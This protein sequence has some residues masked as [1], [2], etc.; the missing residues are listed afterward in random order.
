MKPKDRHC[1]SGAFAST[2]NPRAGSPDL[3]AL[4]GELAMAAVSVGLRAFDG[5]LAASGF[6]RS[7]PATRAGSYALVMGSASMVVLSSMRGVEDW[8]EVL[9]QAS[10]VGNMGSRNGVAHGASQGKVESA[11]CCETT[12]HFAILARPAAPGRGWAGLRQRLTARKS[13]SKARGQRAASV[14]ALPFGQ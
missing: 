10:W 14:E 4:I 1:A 6:L 9:R 5:H 2:V 7:L 12:P 13:R 3:L 11:T 8:I